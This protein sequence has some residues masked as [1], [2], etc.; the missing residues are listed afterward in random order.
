MKK[1]L[2]FVLVLVMAG[3]LGISLVAQDPIREG[4][5]RVGLKD[6]DQL[7][8]LIERDDITTSV[9]IRAIQ[10]I[11]TLYRENREEAEPQAQKFIQ[12][13]SG[14]LQN[15]KK[16]E[17]PYFHFKVRSSACM[18]LGDFDNSDHGASAIGVIKEALLND[19]DPKVIQACAQ[20]LGEFRNN[21][22]PAADALIE[23][24]NK[25]MS[26]PIIKYGDVG[27]MSVSIASLAKLKQKKAFIPLMKVL[28]SGYPDHVKKEAD[29]AIASF[30]L[31]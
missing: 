22:S 12:S 28:Q 7:L 21:R 18:A 19:P 17:N 29:R 2:E 5:N 3:I 26:E 20:S 27:V 10:R 14:A 13:L 8:K 6:A 25:S 23:R 30:D 9:K 4:V 31:E 1:R 15:L 16:D 24:V 11:A